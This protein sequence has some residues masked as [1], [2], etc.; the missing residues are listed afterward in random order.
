MLKQNRSET[1]DLHRTI[2]TRDTE[3]L[4]ERKVL[5]ELLHVM[6]LFIYNYFRIACK[7]KN[8]FVN[9]WIINNV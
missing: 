8:N 6:L 5:L 9:N 1:D 2:A 4:T 3:L 7:L